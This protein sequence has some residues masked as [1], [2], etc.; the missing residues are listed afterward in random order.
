MMGSLEYAQAR[1]SARFGTRPDELAWRRIE[2]LRELPALIDAARTGALHVWMAGI[3]PMSTPH[4]IDRHIR[5]RWREQVREVA[6]WMPDA[7]Q[8]AVA[9]CA[10]IADL[11]VCAHLARGGAPAAWMAD[12]EL[13]CDLCERDSTGARTAPPAGPLAPLAAAWAESDRI[14]R[15]WLREWQRRLPHGAL[16]ETLLRELVRAIAVHLAL[17]RDPALADGEALRR[18]LAVRLTL[19]FRRAMLDPAAAFVYLALIAQDGERLRGELV[20]RA[21][22]PGVPLAA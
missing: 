17:F 22:L 19:L 15:I 20:R 14:G 18:A 16:E 12:D 11:A 5:E 4:E 2:H 6:A 3:G 10:V 8:P 13:Y 1:L 21:A 7:W 9:W